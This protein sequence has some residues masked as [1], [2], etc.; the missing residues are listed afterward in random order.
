MLELLISIRRCLKCKSGMLQYFVNAINQNTNHLNIYYLFQGIKYTAFIDTYNIAVHVLKI[1]WKISRFFSQYQQLP[2]M[3][4][5]ISWFYFYCYSV[6]RGRV[7]SHQKWDLEYEVPLEMAG[8]HFDLDIVL[9]FYHENTPLLDHNRCC[10]S[11]NKNTHSFWIRSEQ[12][13]H[14]SLYL[15]VVCECVSCFVTCDQNLQN[16]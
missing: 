6:L 11:E 5:V 7:R 14:E 13:E 12:P 4:L 1:Q 3:L 8:L 10:Q 2:T 9:N 15:V 16:R